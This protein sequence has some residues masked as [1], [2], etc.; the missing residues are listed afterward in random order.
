MG[1]NG[2]ARQLGV[3][4]YFSILTAKVRN[5]V[6]AGLAFLAQQVRIQLDAYTGDASLEAQLGCKGLHSM[7]AAGMTDSH[8]QHVASRLYTLNCN[9]KVF[10]D[11]YLV[12]EPI[13]LL[14]LCDRVN[15]MQG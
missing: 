5:R 12:C 2:S 10:C 11:N 6:P 8:L 13:S 1:C 14:W 3:I 7:E 4:S 9:W 15:A